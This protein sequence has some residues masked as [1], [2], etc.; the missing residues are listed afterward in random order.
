GLVDTGL[1][2]TPGGTPREQ[3]V[4]LCSEQDQG[5]AKHADKQTQ[6]ADLGPVLAPDQPR[7][8]ATPD[9]TAALGSDDRRRYASTRSSSATGWA[10]HP[11]AAGIPPSRTSR[12]VCRSLWTA[13]TTGPVRSRLASVRGPTSSRCSARRV[14]MSPVS[15]TRP[16]LSTTRWSQ[17][18]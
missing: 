9:V 2:R 10:C 11:G 1:S 4:G 13:S 17:T 18:R 14:S 5:N 16:W 3:V 8:A 12:V 15:V 6:D 7:H